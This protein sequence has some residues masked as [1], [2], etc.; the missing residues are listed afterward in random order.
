MHTAHCLHNLFFVN[1]DLKNI[2]Y[3]RTVH[4]FYSVDTLHRRFKKMTQTFREPL[5]ET[6]I[7]AMTSLPV[8]HAKY[9]NK[10]TIPNQLTALKSNSQF[11]DTLLKRAF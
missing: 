6:N 10:Y 1:Q 8:K 3:E 11:R 2:S 7:N 5:S 9:D 4:A